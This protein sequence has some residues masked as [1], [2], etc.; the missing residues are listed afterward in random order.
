MIIWSA[1]IFIMID[2]IKKKKYIFTR[3]NVNII[4][5]Y[6]IACLIKNI[7]VISSK[8]NSPI[9]RFYRFVTW[10]FD[11]I[12]HIFSNLSLFIF[13]I[14]WYSKKIQLKHVNFV[15]LLFRNIFLQSRM[16]PIVLDCISSFIDFFSIM[17]IDMYVKLKY[18]KTKEI[19]CY[20]LNDI[21][22]QF[23]V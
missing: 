9:S 4:L 20:T 2:I 3:N 22:K 19:N 14:Q 8:L 21:N 12:K 16:F 1:L 17:Y 6:K 23:Y 10:K 5:K 15:F 11:K 18:I 7:N 13:Y